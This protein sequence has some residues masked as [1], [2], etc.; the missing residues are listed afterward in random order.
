M[1]SR[2]RIPPRVLFYDQGFGQGAMA[3]ARLSSPKSALRGH[4]KPIDVR[5]RPTRSGGQGMR[6]SSHDAA[7]VNKTRF[8]A[9]AVVLLLISGADLS[10]AE[11]AVTPSPVQEDAD[12]HDVR[13]IGSH[14]GWAVGDHGVVWRTEDGGDSWKL[15]A[16]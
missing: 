7:A 13:F 3:S 11:P 8:A 1:Q 5:I 9:L 4:A 15:L 12:L 2:L 16:A 10:A 6:K 14:V